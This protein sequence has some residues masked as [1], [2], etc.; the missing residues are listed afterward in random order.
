MKTN[1]SSLLLRLTV[2]LYSLVSYAFCLGSL[3]Y[4]A[5]FIGNFVVPKSIDSTPT[6]SLGFALIINALLLSVF[7]VQHSVMARPFFKR[8]L[9]RFVPEPAERSTYVLMSSLALILLFW[10]WRPMGGVIWDIQNSVATGVLHGG[11]AFG[12]VL[13]V[14]ATFLINHFDLFGL[15]QA[16]FFLR[17]RS[18]VPLQFMTPGPYRFVRHPMY[19]GL[20]FAF[21]CT[22]TMTVAHLFFAL[23]TT[24]YILVGIQLEERG[25]V[26]ALGQ[27]YAEYRKRTPMLIP[28]GTNRSNKVRR[29]AGQVA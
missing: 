6:D 29:D 28:G 7:A 23:M 9:T 18:Y 3:A 27:D 10:Q 11:F 16:W 20:L 22:P 19:V 1:S 26:D 25:L 4:A 12:W 24:A 5:G 2:A 15:R 21:W 14:G 8:W 17:D 13:V